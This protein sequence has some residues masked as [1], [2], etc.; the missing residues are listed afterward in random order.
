MENEIKTPITKRENLMLALNHQKPMW[1]PSLY[2]DSQIVT[3][4]TS[5]DMAPTKQAA[6]FDWFGTR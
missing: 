6:G 1:M 4:K 3:C 2:A 5:R